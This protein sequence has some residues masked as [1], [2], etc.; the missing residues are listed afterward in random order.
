MLL[1]I[2]VS[3]VLHMLPYMGGM[4]WHAVHLGRT[5]LLY[6]LLFGFIF[7]VLP[8]TKVLWRDALIGALIT[9]GLFLLG[10]FAIVKYI[11]YA[12]V[13]SVYGAAGSLFIFLV[14]V[15]YSSLIVFFGAEVTHAIAQRGVTATV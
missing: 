9:S 6:V 7:K 10:N 1:S 5:L 14:Y 13:G 12:S 4:F 8:D 3:T 2:V 15:Y 11:S